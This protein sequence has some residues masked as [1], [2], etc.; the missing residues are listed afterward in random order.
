MRIL[1]P[2]LKHVVYPGLSKS[3]Y[4]RRSASDGP[5][6][7]TYHG[8]LPRGYEA[9]DVALDGHLI[10][11][12]AF[13]RQIRILKERYNVI[14]PEQFLSWSEK[15]LELP[16]KAVLLT[17][18]DGLINTVSDMLPI[19]RELDVP[20]LFFITGES[21]SEKPGM[22]WYE[23]LYLWLMGAA[24]RISLK[25]P[26]GN[27]VILAQSRE[28]TA[29]RW[30]EYMRKLSAFDA[31]SRNQILEDMRTQLGIPEKWESEYSRR[32]AERRRFFMLD[33]NGVRNLV[34]AGMTIGAH[35]LSHPMLSRMS[36][37][38]AFEEIRQSRMALQAALG[39]EIWALA[40]PFGD[41]DSVSPREP[42]LARRAGFKCA[43]LNTETS[44]ANDCFALP[45][46]HVSAGMGP[47]E[48]EAH[49][50]GFYRVTRAKYCAVTGASV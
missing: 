27:D 23:K 39:T 19:I 50:S 36:E 33:R 16:A 40:F 20:F 2:F 9:R 37:E 15:K 25:L 42:L 22:L 13:T 12:E 45:R 32:E 24:D 11:A 44:F 29:V 35:T 34:D 3:G 21:L 47:A 6:V 31:G 41:S 4:L 43:F 28:R 10:T 18:D 8:I 38:L 5:T 49:V 46:V 30:R 14:A 1:S 48:F 7:V 26:W 17:C